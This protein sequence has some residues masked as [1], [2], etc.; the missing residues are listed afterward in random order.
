MTKAISQFQR[1]DK[2]YAGILFIGSARGT[3]KFLRK[4]LRTPRIKPI[5]VGSEVHRSHILQH[6][7][8]R[9]IAFALTMQVLDDRLLAAQ[10]LPQRRDG[11]LQHRDVAFESIGNHLEGQGIVLFSLGLPLDSTGEVRSTFMVA[12]SPL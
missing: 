8:F 10:L 5:A 9:L 11:L 4:F 3:S 12:L 1:S 2:A 7:E 6:V